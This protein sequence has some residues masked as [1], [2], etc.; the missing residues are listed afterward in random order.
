MTSIKWKLLITKRRS[1]Q[2][3]YQLGS[4]R[5]KRTGKHTLQ[6]TKWHLCE[7]PRRWVSHTWRRLPRKCGAGRRQSQ[8]QL[9]KT[10]PLFLLQTL[11]KLSGLGKGRHS[12]THAVI[13]YSHFERVFLDIFII[14]PF[15]LP[16]LR[17][18][19]WRE[20]KTS[21]WD[22]MAVFLHCEDSPDYVLNLC[23]MLLSPFFAQGLNT[24]ITGCTVFGLA[25]EFHIRKSKSL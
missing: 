1:S 20:T 21:F 18:N 2:H 12:C 23:S 24:T 16:V 15:K 4:Q 25:G 5:W 10:A 13:W 19:I 11:P 9:P 8:Q 6:R 22:G 7:T 3:I 14:V 17:R